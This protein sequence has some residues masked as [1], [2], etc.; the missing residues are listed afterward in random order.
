MP[1]GSSSEAPVIRP[2]PR[3]PINFENRARRPAAATGL[4]VCARGLPAGEPV[5]DAPAIGLDVFAA[6]RPHRPL[7][8]ANSALWI[9]FPTLVATPQ[10][11][12]RAEVQSHRLQAIPANTLGCQIQAA[13]GSRGLRYI[14]NRAARLHRAQCNVSEPGERSRDIAPAMCG[15]VVHP[16][17]LHA[18]P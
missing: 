13:H 6:R 4:P 9:Y 1:E 7:I 11:R 5:C 15:S 2:G 14:K 3:L 17:P 8:R 10:F 18:P 12:G 16:A